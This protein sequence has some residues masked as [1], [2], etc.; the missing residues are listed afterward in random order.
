MATWPSKFIKR[1]LLKNHHRRR[2]R[3]TSAKRELTS[4]YS[5]TAYRILCKQAADRKFTSIMDCRLCSRMTETACPNPVWMQSRRKQIFYYANFC[6]INL[7]R[8]HRS[9]LIGIEYQDNGM[10][11]WVKRIGK[12]GSWIF[13]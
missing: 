3:T 7:Q 6:K 8:F 5:R 10:T 11:Q 9:V 12:W 2:L 13:L 1:P 4:H